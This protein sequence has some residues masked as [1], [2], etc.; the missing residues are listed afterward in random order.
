MRGLRFIHT[1]LKNEAISP[2]DKTDLTLLRLDYVVAIN[3]DA[4]GEPANFHRAHLVPPGPGSEKDSISVSSSET[5]NEDEIDFQ[6]F[7]QSL[8]EEFRRKAPPAAT[9]SDR[10]RAIIVSAPKRSDK[11]LEES[12]IETKD[13]ARSCNVDVV[14]AFIQYRNQPD[15]K[16]LVG[17]GKLK[18][19]ILR[20]MQLDAELLIFDQNLTPGLARRISDNTQLKIIDRTQLILDVFALR[21]NSMDGKLQVELAQLKYTLPRLVEKDTMMSRLTGGIGG[22]GPGETKLEINR[23]RAEERI[24]RL[25][26]EIENLSKKRHQKR[27]MRKRSNIPIISIVGYTNAGKSTLLNNLTKSVVSAENRPFSTLDPASRRLRFPREREVIITDTVGFIKDL[28]ADLINAFRAT[29][30]EIGD[31]HLLLHIVDIS[32]SNYRSHID[33]VDT[34]LKELN[35]HTIPQIRV[36]NKI[37]KLNNE[38]LA[39]ILSRHTSALAISALKTDSFN[40]LINRMQRMLWNNLDYN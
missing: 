14:D 37:D 31:A 21:A 8:E 38:M 33:S 6:G 25:E 24:N 29:L 40:E 19:L 4:K 7:I 35:Y 10:E 2:E 22:R 16:Y 12:L 28:P 5:F 15:P 36:F 13:L 3:V 20:A 23:R 30:E 11:F 34:I 17:K 18:D 9:R 1:H 39:A 32:D 26:K 27:S